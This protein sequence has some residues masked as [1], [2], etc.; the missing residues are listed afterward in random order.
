MITTEP[1][2][3][4]HEV[5]DYVTSHFDEAGVTLIAHGKQSVANAINRGNRFFITVCREGQLLY[6]ADGFSQFTNPFP[7]LNPINT[8]AKTEKYF[9]HQY[10]LVVGFMEA[11][12]CCF[13]AEFYNNCLFLL[14]QV[15]E[16]VCTV[17]IRVYIGYHS[18]IHH[19]G[20]LLQ[21]CSCF[22]EIPRSLFP[23]RTAEEK[24]LYQLLLKS[25]SETRYKDDFDACGDDVDQLCTT[26]SNFLEAT[27][28]LC[29]SKIKELRLAAVDRQA[30][31][32]SGYR[33]AVTASN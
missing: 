12:D 7:E 33:S 1:K 8:L 11:A 3:I 5:Q 26:A 2:R 22:S 13:E 30:T 29:I 14:H 4:E 25:Y 24:R 15:I 10:K 31:Q 32:T 6:S 16:Q 28:K 21:L 20:R 27:E 18:D 23:Q 9:Y 17:L 19:I